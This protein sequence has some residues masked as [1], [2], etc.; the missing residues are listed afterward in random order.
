MGDVVV[1]ELNAGDTDCSSVVIAVHKWFKWGSALATFGWAAV[2]DDDV[3]VDEHEAFAVAA[4]RFSIAE[5][6]LIIIL[7][8]F[9]NN[10]LL[11]FRNSFTGTRKPDPVEW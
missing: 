11:A 8:V 4:E 10:K 9:G 3:V 5:L 2:E 6:R 7:L 1:E